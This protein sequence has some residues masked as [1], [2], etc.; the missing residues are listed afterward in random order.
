M[1]Q[2]E[3]RGLK[4]KLSEDLG[5]EEA[6][7][8]FLPLAKRLRDLPAP[9]PAPEQ[10]ARLA[11]QMILTSQMEHAIQEGS[12]ETASSFSRVFS[13][14][15]WLLL[16]SQARLVGQGLW[17]ISPLVMLL[18]VG[19]AWIGY[20]PDYG[21]PLSIVAPLVA[22]VGMAFVYGSGN[23]QAVEIELSTPLPAWVLL[24]ARMALVFTFNLGLGL[25]ASAALSLSHAGL[26]FWPLVIAWLAPMAFLSGLSFF[27]TVLWNNSS[28]AISLAM[29][30]WILLNLLR[31]L[32]I[33]AFSL[34]EA[35]VQVFTLQSAPWLSALALGL[36][37]LALRLARNEERWL[38]SPQ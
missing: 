22:A 2:S 35:A 30:F 33:Q 13:T 4:A 28:I 8:Q 6:A 25:A 17:I 29:G 11:A 36:F 18:G 32:P 24:L 38:G 27:I 15:P 19:I 9:Q 16:L 12:T 21:L 1:T 14:L 31:F 20:P 3:D 37:A 10:R 5:S 23:E 26:S 34:S 7:R